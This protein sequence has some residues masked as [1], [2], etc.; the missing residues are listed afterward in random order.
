M[1]LVKKSVFQNVNSMVNWN[2]K[3]KNVLTVLK[4]GN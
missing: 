4:E 1:N 3:M 2:I